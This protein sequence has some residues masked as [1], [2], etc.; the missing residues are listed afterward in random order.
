MSKWEHQPQVEE[1]AQVK[2]DKL[3]EVLAEMKMM[4]G[5]SAVIW[6][7]TVASVLELV[8]CIRASGTNVQSEAFHRRHTWK[9]W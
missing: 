7:T 5:A 3:I 8:E 4:R 6:S 9:M 2:T 1:D